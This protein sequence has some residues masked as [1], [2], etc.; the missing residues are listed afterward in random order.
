MKKVSVLLFCLLSLLQF[1]ASSS[2]AQPSPASA[3]NRIISLAPSVT[4]MLFALGLGSHMVANTSYC[5]FPAEAAALPHLGGLFDTNL[6]AGLMLSPDIV[7]GLA[8]SKTVLSSFERLGVATLNISDRSIQDIYKSHIKICALCGCA[9]QAERLNA[10]LQ[11]QINNLISTR[12]KEETV[13]VALIVASS[14][15]A[16]AEE[17]YLSGNDG[18]YSSIF[19]LLNAKNVFSNNTAAIPSG[20][21][22]TLVT[23]SPGLIFVV[24]ADSIRFDD[25]KRRISV[26]L[27]NAKLVQLSGDYSVVPGPRFPLLMR[28]IAKGLELYAS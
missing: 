20:S 3:C 11:N 26:Y 1:A 7:I 18:Y 8:E 28:D 14:I 9:K 17:L 5:K 25:L 24:E 6:E 2:F 10:D 4:E 22:E 23:L 16:G 13:P 27:P 12:E 19:K 15:S 21:Y